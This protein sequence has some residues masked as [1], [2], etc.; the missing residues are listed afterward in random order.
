MDTWKILVDGTDITASV[1]LFSLAIKKTQGFRRDGA[2]FAVDNQSPSYDIYDSVGRLRRT[3]I[4]PLRSWQTVEIWRNDTILEFGGVTML[5]DSADAGVTQDNAITCV[6]WS[7]L[8]DARITDGDR[9]FSEQSAGAII[10]TLMA[11]FV[12]EIDATLI[13][14]GATISE[15]TYN[16]AIMSDV[17]RDLA[18]MSGYNYYVKVDDY[19]K[20]WLYFQPKTTPV[21]PFDLSTA[22]VEPASYPFRVDDWSTEGTEVRNAVTVQYADGVVTRTDA[23]SQTL[24]GYELAMMVE[25]GTADASLATVIADSMLEAYKDEMRAGRAVCW[26]GGLSPGQLI[27][28]YHASLGIDD[29]YIIQDVT[30]R[31][32]GEKTIYELSLGDKHTG[33]I[34]RLRALGGGG[35]SSSSSGGVA[36]LY[37]GR[38]DGPHVGL[39]RT[40]R[41]DLEHNI[42][43]QATDTGN[44]PFLNVGGVDY[45]TN[46]PWISIGYVDPV[47]GKAPIRL[48]N[49]TLADPAPEE[50][51]RLEIDAQ[52][53]IYPPRIV[54]DTVT[55]Q[56]S[57]SMIVCNKGSAMTVN[58]LAATGSGRALVVKNIGAGAATVDGASAET[59]DGATTLELAT[60]DSVTIIDYDTGAWAIVARYTAP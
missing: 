35:S 49:A 41:D 51:P 59:I 12:P 7:A 11:E 22:P 21:A 48:A 50:H 25:Y 6:D 32:D 18:Q 14:N 36:K 17:I 47:T 38:R 19:S 28:V 10:R 8:L 5:H 44:T 4:L 58:L 27:G 24:Y 23:D 30:I 55:A 1:D 37:V 52:A 40:K 26:Q 45:A 42:Y 31:P 46:A 56:V 3:Y 57:D 33:L 43:L 34:D 60:D 29:D 54:T 15:I 2:R 13:A 16:Y 39:F 9:T 20:V 53:V